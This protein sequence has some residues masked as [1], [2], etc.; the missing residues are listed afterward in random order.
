MTYHLICLDTPSGYK[1][2]MQKHYAQLGVTEQ[3]EKGKITN[4]GGIIEAPD[5]GCYWMPLDKY[6]TH[7]SPDEMKFI[8]LSGTGI[9]AIIRAI[10]PSNDL[11]DN[12]IV[13]YLRGYHNLHLG[14]YIGVNGLTYAPIKTDYKTTIREV[15]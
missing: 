1:W 13:N 6:L 2:F 7:Y 9:S 12:T 15:A 11:Y 5:N 3:E 10:S 14:D 8:H 4:I